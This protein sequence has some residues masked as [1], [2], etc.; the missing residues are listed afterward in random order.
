M[1]RVRCS[2]RGALISPKAHAHAALGSVPKRPRKPRRLPV[3]PTPRRCGGFAVLRCN[4]GQSPNL[5]RN[6]ADM[7]AKPRLLR[8]SP[9][10]RQRGDNK[11][12]PKSN[13]EG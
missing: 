4:A 5:A 1:R 10:T 13:D 9:L 2:G 7:A 8:E 12:E 6:A 11:L 3:N